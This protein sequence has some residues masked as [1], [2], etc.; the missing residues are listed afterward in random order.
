MPPPGIEGG[1]SLLLTDLRQHLFPRKYYGK[2]V[3]FKKFSP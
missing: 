3:Y 2:G 1:A